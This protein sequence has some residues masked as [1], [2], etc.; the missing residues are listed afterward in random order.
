MFYNIKHTAGT[1]VPVT[2]FSRPGTQALNAVNTQIILPEDPSV[3]RKGAM[4]VVAA[5]ANYVAA[6]ALA[7]F[8]LYLS[9]LATSVPPTDAERQKIDAA[10][11][12]LEAK[13]FEQEAFL[14]R[15][16]TVFRKS[17]NWLNGV[18]ESE[19]AYAATNFPFG[20]MTIYPDFYEKATDD[21]ERAMVLLHEARHIEGADERQAY[22]Y[23][24]EN[25]AKLGWTTLTHGT[26][27]T[28]VTIELQT[29]ENAPE[30]FKCSS[31]L[32]NDC[33]ERMRASR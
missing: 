31:N 4:G 18:A 9:L 11:D 32:W 21:T 5:T 30:L 33:T 25:R 8:I 17:D 13:G 12:V 2:Q 23:V 28:Y 20:I 1:P 19:N 16:L 22:T 10:I 27:P 29:R 3:P 24:W 15:H 7:V 14:L 6:G 26:T